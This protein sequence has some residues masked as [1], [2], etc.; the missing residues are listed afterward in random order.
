[1][2]D[3]GLWASSPG[4][5][6]ANHNG[7]APF[8]GPTLWESDMT[9]YAEPPPPGGNGSH[10]DM[11]HESPYSQGIAH[12][13]ANIYWVVDGYSDDVVRY[14]FGNDHGP[15]QHYHGDAIVRRFSDFSIQKDP[16]DHIVSHCVLDKENDMLYVVDHGNQRVIRLDINTGIIGGTPPFAS[17]EQLTEY[18]MV[19]G[20]D[21]DVII[22]SGLI[23]PAPEIGSVPR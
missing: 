7:G 8:T 14:D 17:G 12:E 10:M 22:T 18:T 16:N 4:V 23:E 11:L 19:T 9:I 1:M 6:D 13:K 15:G 3:N 2:G 20:F 21:W 5:F